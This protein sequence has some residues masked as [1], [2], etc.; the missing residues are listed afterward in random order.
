MF[1]HDFVPKPFNKDAIVNHEKMSEEISVEMERLEVLAPCVSRDHRKRRRAR[2]Y[3]GIRKKYK[4]H[5]ETE[6]GEDRW[7]HC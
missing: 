7:V 2:V 3:D 1:D 4:T 5:R 6:K